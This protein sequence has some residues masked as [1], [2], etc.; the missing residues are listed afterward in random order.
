MIGVRPSERGA[1]LISVLLLVAL[2]SVAALAMMEITVRSI[3]QAKTVDERNRLNWHVVGAEQAGRV[4][5]GRFW[6][7]SEGALFDGMAGLGAEFILPV[8]GAD[9]ISRIGEASNCFNLN[10]LFLNGEVDEAHAQAEAN[11]RVLLL[12]AEFVEGDVDRLTDALIDW[13]DGDTIQRPGGAEDSYY[14]NLRPAY[15]TAQTRLANLSE[16]R[17]I[18]G[19]GKAVTERLEDLVCVREDTEMAV[20][21]INTLRPEQSA[22]LSMALSGALESDQARDIILDRP[23]GGWA[24]V[25]ELLGDEAIAQIDPELYQTGLLS[26]RSAYLSFEGQI[27]GQDQSTEFSVLFLMSDTATPRIVSRWAGGRW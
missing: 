20:L 22:L 24:S 2:M 27:I 16:L 11:F 5:V 4:G 15:L 9:I 21:N 12:A 14:A 3:G 25:E 8:E 7:A 6:Q 17:A 10:A 26:I 18:R 23:L 1:A 19:Y 13:M